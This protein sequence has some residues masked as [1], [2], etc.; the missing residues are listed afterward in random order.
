MLEINGIK[1][2]N[3]K[4]DFV[5]MYPDKCPVVLENDMVSLWNGFGE[6]FLRI[7]HIEVTAQYNIQKGIT[8]DHDLFFV[9]RLCNS[10]FTNTESREYV[11]FQKK[12]I[13]RL[14]LKDNKI[15]I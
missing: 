4:H 10:D 14:Y 1:I 2:H 11:F 8:N 12:Y 15:W 9:G 6:T 13:Y 5:N 7:R 3:N